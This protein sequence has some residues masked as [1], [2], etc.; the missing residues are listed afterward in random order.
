VK[1]E[2]DAKQ[3]IVYINSTDQWQAQ[4]LYVAIVQLCK[5][6][7]IAGV[8]VTRGLEGYGGSGRLHTVRLLELSENMPIRVEIVDVAER[9]DPLLSAL[10]P[11]ITEGLVTV[12]DVHAVRYLVAPAAGES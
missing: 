4:P 1:I 9:I 8:T 3:V 7:G 11:M 6:R 2:I 5:S 10:D 12:C